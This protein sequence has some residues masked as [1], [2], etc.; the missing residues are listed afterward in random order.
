MRTVLAGFSETSL[1]KRILFAGHGLALKSHRLWL[2]LI[3]ARP[4]KRHSIFNRTL[5]AALKPFSPALA[6]SSWVTLFSRDNVRVGFY[7]M[8]TNLSPLVKAENITSS[9]QILLDETGRPASRA[10]ARISMTCMPICQP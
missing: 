3:F 10:T 9:V 2:I 5:R 4:P 8:V 1:F 6:D 7:D